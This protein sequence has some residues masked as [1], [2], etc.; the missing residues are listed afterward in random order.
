M[1]FRASEQTGVLNNAE[2]SPRKTSCQRLQTSAIQWMKME[3]LVLTVVQVMERAQ[4]EE[5]KKMR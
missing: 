4:M 5:V 2:G 1:S 3:S